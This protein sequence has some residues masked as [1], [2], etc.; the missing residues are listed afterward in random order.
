M[1]RNYNVVH[2]SSEQ[3]L[4]EILRASALGKGVLDLIAHS[5]PE[6]D[7]NFRLYIRAIHLSE[8]I[9]ESHEDNSF[10][11]PYLLGSVKEVIAEQEFAVGMGRLEITGTLQED[12]SE[13]PLKLIVAEPDDPHDT[14]GY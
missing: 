12:E 10:Q 8:N 9:G 4:G 1:I 5:D 14:V 3:E 2:P 7:R 13:R 6:F 11:L